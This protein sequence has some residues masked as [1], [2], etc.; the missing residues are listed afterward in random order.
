M[1]R[2]TIPV[3]II[4]P[5]II[6]STYKEPCLGWIQG[7]RRPLKLHKSQHTVFLGFVG[8]K[9]AENETEAAEMGCECLIHFLELCRLF[10]IKYNEGY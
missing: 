1:A 2:G 4:R 9:R 8:E 7:N 10:K 5:I 6:E 3:V